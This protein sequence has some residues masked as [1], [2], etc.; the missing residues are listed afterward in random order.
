[1]KYILF[2]LAFFFSPC[3][4]VAESKVG[5]ILPL[6]GDFA[7][8]GEKVQKVFLAK[9]A[10]EVSLVFEDEACNAKNAL[11][12]YQKLS[13]VD[14]IR[15]FLG[16]GCGTPQTVIAPLL[17]TGKQLALLGTSASQT[18]FEASKGRMYSTQYS[19]E[20]ESE[21]NAKVAFELGAR[22]AVII[23]FDNDFSRAHE[24]AFR[25]N[26][27][28]KVLET[29][30]YTSLDS[31]ILK[32]LALSIRKLKPDLVYVPDAFPLMHGLLKEF[33]TIGFT[34]K[35]ILSVYSA[36]SLDVLEAVGKYGE[37][38]L[39]SYPQIGDK[40]ALDYFPTL[41]VEIMNALVAACGSTDIECA[42]KLLAS[43]YDFNR[44]G[45]LEGN[46]G[47]KTIRDGKFVWYNNALLNDS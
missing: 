6:T 9:K 42:Q 29:L 17:A 26:F 1:M 18:V 36:Q 22:K 4:L 40:E 16:P 31:S 30:S 43:E 10:K 27:Q 14:D 39:F 2:L 23:F 5:V 20:Q 32:S 38:L 46:I 41:A 24:K 7:R 37:G 35:M 33:A 19:I 21:Y 12:A 3:P 15:L 25:E 44:Y 34:K 8:Y 13:K 28:G 11:T 47:V 45:V